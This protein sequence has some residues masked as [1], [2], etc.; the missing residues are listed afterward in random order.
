[1]R[2]NKQWHYDWLTRALHWS[3]ALLLIGLIGLGF[4][5][6]LIEGKADSRWYFNL[7]KSLGIIAGM[8][9]FFRLF[10]RFTYIPAP[11][12]LSI[13]RWQARTSR[14]I[15]VLLYVCMLLMP[16]SGFMGAS[17]GKYGIVFF[18]VQLPI[19]FN[20]RHDLSE[21]F[22]EVH[23]WVAWIF[24]GLIVLHVFAAMKHLLVNKDRVFQR[25]WF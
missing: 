20:Q 14:L 7:H 6:V 22:F 10:W 21:L 15:H 25:M 16:I 3:I 5:M 17:L 9:I 18:G 13:P 1:M 24:V 8:L 12:P 11:L 4:Y 2:D 23:E 19:W